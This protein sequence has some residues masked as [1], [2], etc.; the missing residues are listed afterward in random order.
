VTDQLVETTA[1]PTRQGSDGRYRVVLIDAGDGSSGHYP[2]D[3][4]RRAAADRVFPKGMHVYWDHASATEAAA[5]PERTLRDLS[6][7]LTEDAAWDEAT[8]AL[9]SQVQVFSPYRPLV[10][11]MRDHIGLSING[12]GDIADDAGQRI[13]RRLTH[14]DS[15]DFVTRPGRGGRVLPVLEADRPMFDADD[16]AALA[17]PPHNDPG[18][19][20]RVN[21][22]ARGQE[23]APVA[24]D[25]TELRE[26]NSRL[27]TQLREAEDTATAAT[28]E[29]DEARTEL[30]ELR[31]QNAALQAQI[32]TFTATEA[33]RPV[34]AGVLADAA[35][36]TE[37]T[38]ARLTR[39]ALRD[40][41]IADG[42]LDETVLRARLTEARTDAETEAASYL[43][44]AGRPRGLGDTLTESAGADDEGAEFDHLFTRPISK[45]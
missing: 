19:P 4:L 28:A 43:S 21:E 24:A 18:D 10:E 30:D 40:L 20:P 38:R 3:T 6:A 25:D 14:A 22:A 41:P 16:L 9:V 35:T 39:E 8:Q 5:R 32:A 7:V 33:A 13:V 45:G 31:A 23:G 1:A 29:R 11:E 36:L 15:V 12:R 17:A 44:E 34:I 26:T 27:S 2:P 37:A 42:R